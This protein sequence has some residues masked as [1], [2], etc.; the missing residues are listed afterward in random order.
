MQK[1][2]D[3]VI[4]YTLPWDDMPIDISHVFAEEAPAGKHGFLK[5][6]GE[7][8][9]FEDGTRARF[10]GVNFNS[11]ANFPSHEYSK[12]VARRLAKTGLNMVRFHQLDGDWSTPNIFQFTKGK[13]L[14]N[15]RS[16]DPESMDR[17][18]YLIYC[19]K[20]EGIYCYLDI[21][22]Y[23]RFRTGD[24]VENAVNLPDAARPQSNFDEHLIALQKEF[25]N[26]IWNH[27]NPYTGLAYKDEPAIVMTEIVNENEVF[28]NCGANRLVEPY[29]TQ[30]EDKYYAYCEEKGI[31]PRPRPV[32]FTDTT[33]EIALFK[34]AIQKKY[35]DEMY[36]YLRSL[37]VKIPI[38]G[39]NWASGGAGLIYSQENMDFMDMHPY[40]YDWKWSPRLKQ[41]ASRSS[42][43]TR[44]TWLDA[45]PYHRLADRPFFV[46]EWDMPWPNEYRGESPLFLASLSALQGWGG[47][48][49]HTYRYDCRENV[50]MIAAPITSEA[51]SGIPYRSGPF[52]CFNDPAKY[53]LFYHAALLFRR[54][55]VKESSQMQVF[56]IPGPLKSDVKFEFDDPAPGK[57]TLLNCA[58][59]HTGNY[60][61]LEKGKS[62]SSLQGMK[63][64]GNAVVRDY[65]EKINDDE[66]LL[67]SDTGELTR[68]AAK[69]IALIDTPRTK[70]AYGFLG[71]AGE[72]KLSSGFSIK[73]RNPFAI[74]AVSSLDNKPIDE[75]VNLLLT[76]VGRADNTDASYSD[77]HFTQ[78]NKGHGPIEAEVIEAEISWDSSVTGFTAEAVNTQ[79]MLIG[80]APLTEKDG[81]I[82]V[83]IGQDFASIYYLIQKR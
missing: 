55:D 46:S 83:E 63:L 53:G 23:R 68:D 44:F 54:A 77:D 71:T 57:N 51:L 47:T 62:A 18:D 61:T 6:E 3:R 80:R 38:T 36:A 59:T 15:T 82:T 24:G 7:Y 69:K 40:F 16:L 21:L 66:T 37:G 74:I 76:A 29:R 8:F 17:L 45:L 65:S 81:R 11:N 70:A 52:D 79:G 9:V 4:S 27:V 26:Q 72:L 14:D 67:V 5:C 39:T 22:T 78:F 60:G 42:L 13:Y 34:I 73:C 41:C 33:D 43:A 2:E 35:F 75:S 12:K 28:G 1:N 58:F 10:W 50:D 31:T 64:P 25:C 19:L 48:T 30:L 32:D 49:I 20:E 56:E